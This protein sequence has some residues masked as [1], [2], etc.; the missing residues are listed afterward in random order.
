MPYHSKKPKKSDS[1]LVVQ[2]IRLSKNKYKTQKEAKEQAKKMDFKVSI[3]PNPQYANFWSFRQIQPEKFVK[4]SF[5]TKVVNP[6]ISLI[7]GRLK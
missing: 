4:G 3:K 1:S 2:A 5:R 6:N 7:V